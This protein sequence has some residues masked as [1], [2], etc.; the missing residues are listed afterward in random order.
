MTDGPLLQ[1]IPP[2]AV[3]LAMALSLLMPVFYAVAGRSW[4]SGSVVVQLTKCAALCIL[5]WIAIAWLAGIV[6]EPIAAI[7]CLCIFLI[8]AIVGYFVV[9]FLAYSFRLET[10]LTVGRAPEGLTFD[11]AEATFGGGVGLAGLFNGRIRTLEL[12]GMIHRNG[13]MVEI[14]PF[15]RR[16][17]KLYGAVR[18]ITHW[19]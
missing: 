6:V 19:N 18:F 13:D 8:A 15:G 11:E 3:V 12:S 5:P 10:L 4:P 1:L 16:F 2:P 9:A 14:T 7:A 17:A